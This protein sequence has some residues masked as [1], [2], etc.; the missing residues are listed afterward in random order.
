[1]ADFESDWL[2]RHGV[3]RGIEILSE[4]CRHLPDSLL[5]TRPEVP[6]KQVRGIG[7]LL[8]HEYHRIADD[9]IWAVVTNNLSPLREAI[10]ALQHDLAE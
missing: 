7:N 5:E 4:A 3:Q 6:W 8:R 10:E 9:L 2:L 1:L